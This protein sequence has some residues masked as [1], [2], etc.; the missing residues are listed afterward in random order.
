M[1]VGI[2]YLFHW[3]S[4]IANKLSLYGIKYLFHWL[5]NIANKLSL[6]GIEYLFH[7]LS[8]ISNKLSL[9]GIKCL[10]LWLPHIPNKLTLNRIL[11]LFPFRYSVSTATVKTLHPFTCCSTFTPLHIALCFRECQDTFYNRSSQHYVRHFSSV[12]SRH[13]NIHPP[14]TTS[15]PRYLSRYSDCL[16]AGRSGDR[17]PVRRDFPHLSRPAMRPTQPPVQWVPGLYPGGKVLP[18]RDADPSPPSNAEV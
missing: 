5:S 10:F 6:Y 14:L 4:K 8:Q 17:I 2:K 7:W 1:I 16:R 18:G 3:L 12:D 11:N 13:L 15:G 9:Y